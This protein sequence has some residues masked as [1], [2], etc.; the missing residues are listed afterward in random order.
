[1]SAIGKT[2]VRLTSRDEALPS[3]KP[4]QTTPSSESGDDE[5]QLTQS[6][7]NALLERELQGFGAT[8]PSEYANS[9]GMRL[10]DK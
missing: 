8:R 6:S 5:S 10:Y 9:V 4:E 3:F 2:I 1:M 7:A